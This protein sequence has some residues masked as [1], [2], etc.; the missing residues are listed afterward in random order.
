MPCII[1]LNLKEKNKSNKENLETNKKRL[2]MR[3]SRGERES[4]KR[5]RGRGGNENE[6]ARKKRIEKTKKKKRLNH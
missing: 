6:S 4:R 3:E 1:F 5:E 2:F